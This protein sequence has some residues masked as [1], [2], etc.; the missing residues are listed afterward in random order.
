MAT[1]STAVMTTSYRRWS[2]RR[3]LSHM[4]M[5]S[6]SRRSGSLHL[7]SDDLEELALM[8][9]VQRTR[10]KPLYFSFFL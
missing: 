5:R 2:S 9:Q 7:A 10:K 1:S 6:R 4:R 8:Q 3:R